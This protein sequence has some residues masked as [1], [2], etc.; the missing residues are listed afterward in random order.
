MRKLNRTLSVAAALMLATFVRI[1]PAA[2]APG[3][4]ASV[5][6]ANADRI[7]ESLAEWKDTLAQLD[8]DKK[9]LQQS[10]TEK[11]NNLKSEKASLAYLT[12]GTQQY[13]DQSKKFE[14]DSIQA[15]VWL[16]EQQAGLERTYKARLKQI[17]LEI[18]D[19][20]AQVAQKDGISLVI[21]D[22]RPQLPDDL[23]GTSL[24]EL[25]ARISQ[26][27]VLFSDQSRDISGEV[28]TLLDRNY[29]AKTAAPSPA[30]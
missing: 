1:A 22:Q 6:I 13:S 23:E 7:R 2:D 26:R 17:F 27:T 8:L 28:I 30:K 11:D 25:Q 12:P 24:Q 19:G 20:I 10:A 5:A 9:S 4:T 14:D 15:E 3:G 18:Q 29:A 21:A 16:K